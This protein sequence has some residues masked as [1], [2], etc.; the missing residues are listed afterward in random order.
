MATKAA[1]RNFLFGIPASFTYSKLSGTGTRNNIP[2]SALDRA[3]WRNI[4]DYTQIPNGHRSVLRLI[5][6]CSGNSKDPAASGRAFPRPISISLCE[7]TIRKSGAQPLS[8]V[9]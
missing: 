7:A 3:N 8:E 9:S 5:G 4:A 1:R 2:T 6:G